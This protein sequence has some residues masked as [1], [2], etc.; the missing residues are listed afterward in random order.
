MYTGISRIF[1]SIHACCTNWAQIVWLAFFTTLVPR[2]CTFAS[3]T[4]FSSINV[5]EFFA[6]QDITDV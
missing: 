6:C 4:N 2:T 5:L 1:T 3:T